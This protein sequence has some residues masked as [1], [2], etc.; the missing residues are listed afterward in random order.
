MVFCIGEQLADRCSAASSC[1]STVAGQSGKTNEV[2]E[3]QM[4]ARD[5]AHFGPFHMPRAMVFNVFQMFIKIIIYYYYYV[6]VSLF[7]FLSFWED[8]SCH[9][10]RP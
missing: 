10:F 3:Q 1:S 2:C 6:Y 5:R 8:H 7:V 9:S 4:K